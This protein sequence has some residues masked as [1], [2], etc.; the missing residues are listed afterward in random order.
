MA[1]KERWKM[2]RKVNLRK[3]KILAMRKIRV[4]WRKTVKL[5]MEERQLMVTM[6]LLVLGIQRKGLNLE[7]RKK[8]K[9]GTVKQ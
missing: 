2:E 8:T 4:T 7:R 6:L 1:L 5:L 3:R 9:K